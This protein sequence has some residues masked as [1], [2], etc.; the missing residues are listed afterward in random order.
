MGVLRS[1]EDVVDPRFLFRLL[2]SKHHKEFLSGLTEGANI[3]NLKLSEYLDYEIPLPTLDEQQRI[4]AEIESYQKVIDGAR[5]IVAAYQPSFRIDDAWPVKPVGDIAD[6]QLGKM[7]DKAKHTSGQLMPY[8]R[9][10]NVRWRSIDT[11]DLLQMYFDDD[12]LDRYGLKAGDLLGCEGGEPGRAAV[13]DGRTPDLKYQ[14]ALHRV[15]F[16]IPYEPKLLMYFLQ[17]LAK[18]TEWHNRFQGATIKHFTREM[19]IELPIPV[20]SIE[21]QQRIVKE[22]DA[23]AAEIEAVRALVPRYKAKIDS[24]LDRVLGSSTT[25]S[26]L[27]AAA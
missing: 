26:A 19:F 27:T 25:E 2:T 9:N 22:L 7:L 18:T 14:K 3:N 20:P 24:V 12:E 6:V 4:V 17:A 8:L 10:V 15:R 21:E 1:R 23:E 11:T 5:Q 13:W 16:K